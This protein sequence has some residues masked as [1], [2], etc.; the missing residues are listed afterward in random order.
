MAKKFRWDPED[1]KKLE[2]ILA[3]QAQN[4]AP[5]D[6]RAR[7]NL[8]KVQG[9]T[10]SV[11]NSSTEIP[12]S[13]TPKDENNKSET[14]GVDAEKIIK[15]TKEN[16]EALKQATDQAKKFQ[17]IKEE[18]FNNIKKFIKELADVSESLHS[19]LESFGDKLPTTLSENLAKTI[20]KYNPFRGIKD[21]F[22]G[23]KGGILDS[24]LGFSKRKYIKEEAKELRRKDFSNTLSMDDALK[25]AKETYNKQRETKD[26][27][28]KR[29][30]L[31]GEGKDIPE[32]LTQQINALTG[33]E[34]EQTHKESNSE[35]NDNSYSA[36]EDTEAAVE[37]QA[38][39]EKK[40]ELLEKI[41]ENTRVGKLQ[42][43]EGGDGEE[44]SGGKFSFGKMFAGMLGI[45]FLTRIFRS[46]KSSLM[47]GLL[48]LFNPK[49]ILKALKV[50]FK[51][52]PL[53]TLIAG[54]FVGIKEG[55]EEWKKTGNLKEALLSSLGGIIEFITFGLLDKE[56]L[57]WL[58]DKISEYVIDPIVNFFKIIK[59]WI[60]DKTANIPL[61]GDSVKSLLGEKESLNGGEDKPR[62][63]PWEKRETEIKPE[64]VTPTQGTEVTLGSINN[65]TIKNMPPMMPSNNTVVNAPT[66]NVKQT[67]NTIVKQTTRNPESS[68]NSFNRTRYAYSL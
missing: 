60:I 8:K 67:K 56:S 59:N 51:A 11:K 66:T 16:T 30:K 40:L 1:I 50:A 18:E 26:L 12:L 32:F 20:E 2:D 45:G 7:D 24:A 64:A 61:I 19:D 58:G 46:L 5:G 52:F 29:E 53:V 13:N 37:G 47:K 36:A 31:I 25:Q 35:N 57:L 17:S 6:T 21:I 33:Y 62:K 42:E 49:T 34:P 48:L 27:F 9:L 38:R 44:N 3:L 14:G 65:E 54:L 68:I 41:E 63:Q 22:S 39:E 43:A 15:E 4:A 10:E 55:L 28:A 23:F